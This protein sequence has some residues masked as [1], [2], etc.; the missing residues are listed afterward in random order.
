MGVA[1]PGAKRDTERS[2]WTWR[3]FHKRESEDPRSVFYAAYEMGYAHAISDMSQWAGLEEAV[4]RLADLLTQLR[5]EREAVI[6][7]DDEYK[8]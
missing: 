2:W 8:S 3:H 4:H 1:V 5:L 6:V 7:L